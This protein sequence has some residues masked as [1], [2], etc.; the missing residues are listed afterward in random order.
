MLIEHD[1][2]LVMAC[3]ERIIVLDRG[4]IIAAGTLIARLARKVSCKTADKPNGNPRGITQQ[5][6]VNQLSEHG[7]R[8]VVPGLVQISNRED[9]GK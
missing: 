8:I 1:M 5:S 9:F 6:G 7:E 2:D 4:K 3:V